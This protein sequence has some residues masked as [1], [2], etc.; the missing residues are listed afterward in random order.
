MAPSWW[1]VPP[2]KRRF[3]FYLEADYIVKV[4]LQIVWSQKKESSAALDAS[5]ASSD[6]LTED[7][8]GLEDEPYLQDEFPITVSKVHG[9]S[10]CSQEVPEDVEVDNPDADVSDCVA[11]NSAV[12]LPGLSHPMSR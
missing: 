8:V 10:E 11:R 7:N 6:E 1:S 4:P 3:R 5:Q 9:N 2:Q 12:M